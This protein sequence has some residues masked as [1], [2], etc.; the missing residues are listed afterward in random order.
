ML[1]R[2]FHWILVSSLEKSTG[3]VSV[4]GASTPAK[5]ASKVVVVKPLSTP[6]VSCI[7]GVL[8]LYYAMDVA[9]VKCLW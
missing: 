4:K 1:G 8:F 5:G 9:S 2:V 6:G 7:M 3:F